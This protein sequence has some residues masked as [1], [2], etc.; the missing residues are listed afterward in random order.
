MDILLF[1]RNTQ[2]RAPFGNL[3]AIKMVNVAKL[4]TGPEKQICI[5]RRVDQT[6]ASQTLE[7]ALYKVWKLH[8]HSG[9]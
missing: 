8:F 7:G 2:T 5:I 9:R 3:E 1:I 6:F 4:T